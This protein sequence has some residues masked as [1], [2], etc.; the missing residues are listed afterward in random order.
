MS[1]IVMTYIGWL[2]TTAK[3]RGVKSIRLVVADHGSLLFHSVERCKLFPNIELG[4]CKNILP[5]IP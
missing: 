2:K 3:R 1:V 4:Y 5:G